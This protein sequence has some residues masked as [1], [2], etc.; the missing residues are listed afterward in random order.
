MVVEGRVV[1]LV[2][3]IVIGAVEFV[4]HV[5]DVLV[6]DEGGDTCGEVAEELR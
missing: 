3:S 4:F 5:V 1:Q 6:N 2:F